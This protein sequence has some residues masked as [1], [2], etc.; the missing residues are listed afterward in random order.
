MVQLSFYGGVNEIGGNKILLKSEQ[1][2]IFLDF[3]KSYQQEGLYFEEFLRPRSKSTY[4]DLMRLELLPPIDG[5]YRQDMICPNNFED[6]CTPAPQYWKSSV[7]SYEE[8]KKEGEWA[9]DAVFVSHAHIDHCGYVPYLGNVSLY[10][11]EVTS[12]LMGAIS[13]IGHLNGFDDELTFFKEREMGKVASGVAK[14]E[15][16]IK[17]KAPK[18]R[19]PEPLTHNTKQN[20]APGLDITA[21]DVGH[22]IPGSMCC[23][24]E[25]DDN[26]VLYTGDLRFHGR[27]NPSLEHLDGLKPDVMITEGTRIEE[28]IPDDEEKVQSDIENIIQETSGLVMIGF[29]WKDLERYE[30]IKE[31]TI[32]SGRIPVFDSRLAYIL[33]RLGRDIYSEGGS[34]FLERAQNMLYSKAD[35]TRDQQKISTIEKKTWKDD[36]TGAQ[37]MHLEKGVP[38]YELHNNPEKYV[39]HLDYFRFKNLIDIDPP[40]GSAYVRAQCE[41]FNTKMELSEKRLIQW[42]KHFEINEENDHKPYQIHASGHACGKELQEFV[43]RIQPKILV[44]IH[45]KK[46]CIFTNKAGSIKIL[47]NGDDFSI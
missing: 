6:A 20:I 47:E 18:S 28:D 13:E 26:Q 2:S 38:A 11:S 14:D 3:G 29:A 40:K 9:L 23:L 39:L 1:G 45:T 36:K 30:T 7:K 33:A 17:T 41:P 22:S 15:V 5:I 37:F 42:L 27:S 43:D 34:V 35:Y 4:Y 8:A 31:A 16:N 21:F 25:T 32:K 12:K 46:S 24:I 19:N 44:P 10:C